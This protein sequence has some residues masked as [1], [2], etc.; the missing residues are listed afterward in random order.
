M[1]DQCMQFR[2]EGVVQGV[3]YRANTQDKARELGLTGWARNEAD[4]TVTVLA[5]GAQESLAKLQDW[6][7]EGPPAAQVAK[8]TGEVVDLVQVSGFEVR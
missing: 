3:F 6:L 2:V 1:A 5:C 4:G 7:W 8:V